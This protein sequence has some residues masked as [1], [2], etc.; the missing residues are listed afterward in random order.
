MEVIEQRKL[1]IQ[2]SSCSIFRQ[3]ETLCE[4]FIQ[5]LLLELHHHVVEDG[6]EE[7]GLAVTGNLV[8]PLAEMCLG[9]KQISVRTPEYPISGENT[10]PHLSTYI[11]LSAAGDLL[12][13]PW[14]GAG[15]DGCG[16][17]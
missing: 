14:L 17:H 9:I 6:V 8:F 2:V 3:C 13:V 10:W 1:L 11:E 12:I 5:L 7:V 4:E 15:V 16:G